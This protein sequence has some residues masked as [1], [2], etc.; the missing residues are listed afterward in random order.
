MTRDLNGT[1]HLFSTI[2]TS[3]YDLVLIGTYFAHKMPEG[4]L[5]LSGCSLVS[6]LSNITFATLKIDEKPT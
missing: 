4:D 3:D 1:A 2:K 6:S 5:T